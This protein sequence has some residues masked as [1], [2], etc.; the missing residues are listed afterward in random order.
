MSGNKMAMNQVSAVFANGHGGG[1]E[2]HPFPAAT[3][4]QAKGRLRGG[5]TDL[6][7]GSLVVC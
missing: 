4:A 7:S 6:I 2:V 1:A 3:A 5:C